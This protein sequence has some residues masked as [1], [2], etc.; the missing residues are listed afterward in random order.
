MLK[1]L[2]VLFFYQNVDIERKF[3]GL[4][5]I[6]NSLSI[7]IFIYL[8]KL[9]KRNFTIPGGPTKPI[10]PKVRPNYAQGA[11]HLQKNLR[12]AGGGFNPG[13]FNFMNPGTVETSTI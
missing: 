5:K 3:G 4:K 1:D 10:M 13:G 6:L 11:Q 2:F 9:F 7:L 12:G 8:K